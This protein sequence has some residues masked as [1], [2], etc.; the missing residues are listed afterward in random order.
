MTASFP[1]SSPKLADVSASTI[2][3]TSCSSRKW[4]PAPSEPI[5]L[6]PRWYARSETLPGSAPPSAPPSSDRSRSRAVPRPCST[7]HFAPWR[8]IDSR[9]FRPGSRPPPRPVPVGIALASSWR[10]PVQLRPDRRH[11]DVAAQQAHAAPDVVADPARRDDAVVDAE[12]GDAPDREPVP[13]VD[14]GHGVRSPDD[15]RQAGDVTNLL[16][17][18]LELPGRA[19]SARSRTRVRA[20][21][22]APLAGSS[23]S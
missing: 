5:V 14:V 22:S 13:P 10:R 18:V 20:R 8:R 21:A 2:S 12:R 23:H 17:R 16:E 3:A 6:R 1:F 19:S 4:L 11:V 9:S 15:P 7:A